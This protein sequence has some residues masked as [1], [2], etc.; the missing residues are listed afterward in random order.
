MTYFNLIE[1]LFNLYV[2]V[3]SFILGS[4]DMFGFS[5]FFFKSTYSHLGYKTS[6]SI[7]WRQV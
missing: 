7:I 2:N 5:L 3:G 4:F 1:Q 6:S